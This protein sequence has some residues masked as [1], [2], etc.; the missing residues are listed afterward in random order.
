M[1]T[2]KKN[3]T[4]SHASKISAVDFLG[5]AFGEKKIFFQESIV[6]VPHCKLFM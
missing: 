6:H 3:N 5:S 4:Q 2:A 1:N